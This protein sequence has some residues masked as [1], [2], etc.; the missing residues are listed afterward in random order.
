MVCSWRW[1]GRR[2]RERAAGPMCCGIKGGARLCEPEPLVSLSRFT[3]GRDCDPGRD[4]L[5]AVA[6]VARG[7]LSNQGHA[8]PIGFQR[9]GDSSRRRYLAWKAIRKFPTSLFQYRAHDDLRFERL[10]LVPGYLLKTYPWFVRGSRVDR[11][12]SRTHQSLATGL[13]TGRRRLMKFANDP[14]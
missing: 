8:S 9:V 12:T 7:S 2:L 11:S 6:S 5:L 1:C 14:I 4:T 10:L 3:A 13:S